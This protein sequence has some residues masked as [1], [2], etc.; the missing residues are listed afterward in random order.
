MNKWK[1]AGLIITAV[2]VICLAV[3]GM[4]GLKKVFNGDDQALQTPEPVKVEKKTEEPKET[5]KPKSTATPVPEATVSPQAKELQKQVDK[6]LANMTLREKIGQMFMVDF[7]QIGG[8][9]ST[10]VNQRMRSRL[11]TYP[12]GGVVF[13]S[14]NIKNATQVT[15]FIQEL[16]KES[17]FP[18]FI[19]VEEEGGDTSVLGS[20]ESLEMPKVSNLSAYGKDEDVE[21]AKSAASETGASM[22]ALGFNLNLGP[23]ADVITEHKHTELEKRS[24]GSDAEL[25]SRIVKEQVL[26]YQGQQVSTAVKYFPGYGGSEKSTKDG[27][28]ETLRSKAKMKEEEWL[29]YVA[30]M[31]SGA[32]CI[33]VS[34]MAAPELTGDRTPCA[35]SK[36]VV[37]DIL[38]GELGYAGVVISAP[39][40]ERAITK[41]YSSSE[42][43]LKAIEAGV[44]VLCMPGSLDGTFASVESAVKNGTISLE[45]IEQ[46]VRRILA[47]KI[48]R[49][50]INPEDYDIPKETRE[51]DVDRQQWSEE[52]EAVTEEPTEEAEEE[53]PKGE[54]EQEPEQQT[55]PKP[56][57]TKSP[58]GNE[59]TGNSNN[60]GGSDNTQP[61]TP[62]QS[63]SQGDNNQGGSGSGESS[64]GN[65]GAGNGSMGA[66]AGS[67]IGGGQ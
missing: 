47:V 14:K 25:V 23:V 55:T 61:S 7:S 48:V 19:A 1:N 16:Q 65:G 54:P 45:R 31:Q 50:I 41:Y 2:L 62:T 33:M 42:A 13:V 30:A 63:P 60:S 39:L 9:S 44:D 34:N 66:G 43:V 4:F 59:N 46:S 6:I 64:G 49:G 29:P 21:G 51:P 38:R 11:H 27:Y 32:D 12:V 56:E 8:S 24:A 53:E 58:Q 37:S 57:P 26:A 36:V 28:A 17:D 18:L 52:E 20:N 3:V 22:K 40:S 35:L 10:S 5:E 67:L 15:S